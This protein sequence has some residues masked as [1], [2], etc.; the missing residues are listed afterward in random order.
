MQEKAYKSIE[1]RTEVMSGYLLPCISPRR[2][3]QPVERALNAQVATIDATLMVIIP[4]KYGGPEQSSL[5]NP[6]V[7]SSS[8]DGSGVS[9]N[10]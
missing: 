10:Q 7:C 2:L 1:P 5:E 9:G 4:D 8:D 6:V 3:H